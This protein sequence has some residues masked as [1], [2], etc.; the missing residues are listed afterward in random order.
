[1]I[2]LRGVCCFILLILSQTAF[3]Q[4]ADD[5]LW[6]CNIQ[7]VENKIW[8]EKNAYHKK[9]LNMVYESCIKESNQPQ[10]CKKSNVMCEAYVT[11]Q[12]KPMVARAK[13][14]RA[15]HGGW[16]CTAF[17][18]AAIAW[19]GGVHRNRDAAAWGAKTFCKQRSRV[20]ETC[21]INFVTCY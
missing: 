18:R 11:T 1:M 9:A 2:R 13:I 21:Y 6:E 15:R 12:N 20:P 5:N 19:R 3:S 7:D 16:Q 10:T 17:D 14:R 4:S 8:S